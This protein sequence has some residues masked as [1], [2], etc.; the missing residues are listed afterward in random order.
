MLIT[1]YNAIIMFVHEVYSVSKNKQ[2]GR[3]THLYIYIY[4]VCIYTYICSILRPAVRNQGLARLPHPRR[5][6]PGPWPCQPACDL[7]LLGCCQETSQTARYG[8]NKE[9]TV[10][11]SKDPYMI[12]GTILTWPYWALGAASNFHR[13]LVRIPIVERFSCCSAA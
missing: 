4:S 12:Y 13:Y 9:Y 5:L 10:N 6:G 2:I 3:C 1:E 11:H 7:T 8:L